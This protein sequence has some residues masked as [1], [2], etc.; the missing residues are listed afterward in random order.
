M[1]EPPASILSFSNVTIEAGQD[2]DSAVWDVTF[3]LAPGELVLVRLDVTHSNLPLAD[4]SQGLADPVEGTVQ[5]IGE[6]WAG[7]TP[8]RAAQ[9]RGRIGRVFDERGWISNL[10]IEENLFLSQEYHTQRSERDIATEAAALSRQFGLP[11]I[12]RGRPAKIRP[13]DLARAACVRAFLG[14]PELLI[15]ESPTSSAAPG[16][17]PALINATREARG[18]GAGILWTTSEL[19]VWNDPG[20]RPT[21]KCVMSGSQMMVE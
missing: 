6:N 10:D 3:S 9:L 17:F 12:P 2:Y 4:A 13:M 8:S 15:L 11:G 21:R 16:L 1:S 5:F 19:S 20:V 7:M 14:Q 18:R